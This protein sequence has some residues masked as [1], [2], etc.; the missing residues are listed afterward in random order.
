[1]RATWPLNGTLL[2]SGVAMRRERCHKAGTAERGLRNG[3]VAAVCHGYPAHDCES[4]SGAG[5]VVLATV[6]ARED[7]LAL[8]FGNAFAVVFNDER[9]PVARARRRDPD[10]GARV[11]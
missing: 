1:M 9:A 2:R 11:A 4:E 7:A 10:G 3:D 8:G 6:E 5:A